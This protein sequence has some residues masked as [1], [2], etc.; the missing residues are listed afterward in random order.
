MWILVAVGCGPGGD[1]ECG[2]G[3]HDEDGICLPD[4]DTGSPDSEDSGDT[5]G[6]TDDSGETGTDG[7]PC[8]PPDAWTGGVPEGLYTEIPYGGDYDAGLAEIA[9]HLPSGGSSSDAGGYLVYDATVIAAGDYGGTASAEKTFLADGHFTLELLEDAYGPKDVRVG[10]RVGFATQWLSAYHGERMMEHATGWQVLSSGNPVAVH[11]L[12]AEALDY[13]ATF[14]R[15]THVSGLLTRPS[16]YDCGEGYRCV[17]L[18]HDGI[19]V[20]V[21]V[22]QEDD[23]GLGADYDGGLC[24]EAVAPVNLYSGEDGEATFLEIAEPDWLRTWPVP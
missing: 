20:L 12:G 5:G 19:D 22:S 13:L 4:E 3:T 6:D 10:D 21:R 17:I 1:Q 7:G 18:D 23:H 11:E 14:N 8:A 24:G 15:L 9:K 2:P 16:S